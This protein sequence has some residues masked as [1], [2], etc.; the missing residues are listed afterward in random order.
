M[1]AV[2]TGLRDP[3]MR[4]SLAGLQ[5]WRP[6]DPSQP[7]ALAA[8]G[9]KL[10]KALKPPGDGDTTRTGVKGGNTVK[11]LSCPNAKPGLGVALIS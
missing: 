7:R 8:R 1:L 11:S 2:P 4:E 6:A 5:V 10:G 9:G 3:V